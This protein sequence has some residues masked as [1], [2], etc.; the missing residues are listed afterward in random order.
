MMYQKERRGL[1]GLERR[2]DAVN[3]RLRGIDRGDNASHR[4]AV[5]YLETVDGIGLV[6]DLSDPEIVVE[7]C[8]DPHQ[9]DRRHQRPPALACI[10]AGRGAATSF[11]LDIESAAAAIRALSFV[12]TRL[13]RVESATYFTTP[14]FSPKT[15]T[16]GVKSPLRISEVIK[17]N[18]RGR[19]M[20]ALPST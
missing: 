13:S 7:V 17:R 1:P 2:D 8:S 11:P 16:R 20:T 4:A 5:L 14:L 19:S 12:G 6:R 18:A 3:R 10:L 15:S 9:R